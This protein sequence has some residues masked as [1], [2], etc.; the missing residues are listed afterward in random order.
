M[1]TETTLGRETGEDLPLPDL[2]FAHWR[3]VYRHVVCNR[4]SWLVFATGFFEPIFYLL[5]I[6]VGVAVLVGQIS[7]PN[8]HRV[9][10]Q[11]F[12]AP[13]ML[14]SAAMNGALME[15]TFNCVFRMRYSKLYDS[16]LATPMRP[17]DV[18]RGEVTWALLR[19]GIYSAGFIVVMVALGLGR[20]WWTGL[21]LLATLAIGYCF[22]GIGLLAGTLMRGWQDFDLLQILILPLFLFSGTFYPLSAYP[23]WLSSII[24]WTPLA[25][26]VELTRGLTT[27]TAGPTMVINVIYLLSLGSAGLC[28]ASRRVTKVLQP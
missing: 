12:V 11:E 17:W 26:G 25:Q 27:G 2:R 18:A 4:R 16:I 8:G 23:A 22:A 19:G 24:V 20:T 6:G 28:L 15:V 10:Y 13:A 5:S 9:P 7:L 21:A 1:A 14:A 3:L